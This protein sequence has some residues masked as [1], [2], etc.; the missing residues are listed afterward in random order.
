MTGEKPYTW[1]KARPQEVIGR[2]ALLDEVETGLLG[3]ESF[4]LLGGRGMGKTVFLTELVRRLEVRQNVQIE[5]IDELPGERTKS[6]CV[7]MLADTLGVGEQRS[8][9]VKAV[10]RAWQTAH[11]GKKLILLYDDVDDYATERGKRSEL[12]RDFFSALESARQH[13]DIGVLADGALVLH[14]AHGVGDLVD[15]V[16]GAAVEEASDAPGAGPG[17][18]GVLSELVAGVEEHGRPLRLRAARRRWLRAWRGRRGGGPGGR[19][20]ARG[21]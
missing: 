7:A 21:R 1:T 4:A 3:D 11:P 17:G 8:G 19:G 6:A 15:A 20:R 14:L 10:L 12:G 5:L 18:V 9:T 2:K 16:V 13:L